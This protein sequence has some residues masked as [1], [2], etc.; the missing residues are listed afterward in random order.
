MRRTNTVQLLVQLILKKG[1]PDL[2]IR[3]LESNLTTYFGVSKH[4]IEREF[5]DSQDG[6]DY[7]RLW[8]WVDYDNVARV[9]ALL[10]TIAAD[11]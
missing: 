9:A 3:M 11:E 4:D 5:V 7:Y 6:K 10:G 8:V 2:Q 1:E